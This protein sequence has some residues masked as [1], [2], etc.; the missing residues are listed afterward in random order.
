MLSFILNREPVETD[1]S[2]GT[3]LLDFIRYEAKLTGTKEAC[4]EGECGACT[5]LIGRLDDDGRPRYRACASCL[6][7][8]GDV[9]GCHVVTVEGVNGE[10]FNAVQKIIIGESASQC[11]YCTPGIVLSLTGFALSAETYS[12]AGALDAL[13]G[14]ICR[15]TGY[16]AIRRAAAK[17]AETLEKNVRDREDRIPALVESGVLP[18]Y[19]L[20]I[21]ELLR[22]LKNSP[23]VPDREGEV[24]VAG[25]TDLFIQRPEEL[26]QSPLFFLSGRRDLD[27][28]RA[29]D[30]SLRVGSAVTLEDFRNHPLVN[31]HL[32]AMKEDVLLHSST[33]LRN[34]ATLAGNIVN[35][36]PI[37]DITIMLLALG[38][39]LELE[40]AGG[41]TRK[42][43]LAKFYRGYKDFDLRPGEI[44]RE[45]VIPI[46]GPRV[47][48]NFE[49]VSN[50]KILDIAAVNSAILLETKGEKIAR[51][52]LSAGGVAP[53]PLLIG[54]LDEFA[55]RKVSPETFKDLA[56][57]AMAAVAPIDDVRGSAEYKRL[58]LGRLVEAHYQEYSTRREN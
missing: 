21:A 43:P 10:E 57:A 4:R 1:E 29:E 19:F 38:V 52:A 2:P 25:G 11:G 37:G 24:V 27:F 22:E 7:P 34:R 51:I 20:G 48:Y 46:P 35:A 58:L 23:A 15:C 31:R 12:Y 44:I 30:G 5:V 41:G 45:I 56:S 55:G 32:P 18:D 26:L 39:V 17:L 13:D 47:F 14:N 8:I 6:L 28:V 9:A 53:V 50:R 42:V 49:K 54:G 36:S 40:A 3:L 16:A 33:I